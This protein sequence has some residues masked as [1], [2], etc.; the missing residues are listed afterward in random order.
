MSFAAAVHPGLASA[1]QPDR[2][3]FLAGGCV[4]QSSAGSAVGA[5]LLEVGAPMAVQRLQT[6][7]SVGPGLGDRTLLPLDLL[8]FPDGRPPTRGGARPSSR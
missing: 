2:L 1:A 3:V 8:L 4:C 5:M 7:I 6:T